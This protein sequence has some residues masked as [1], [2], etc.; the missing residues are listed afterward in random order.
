[1]RSQTA[2]PRSTLSLVAL[3]AISTACANSTQMVANWRDPAATA[4]PLGRTLAVFMSSD[5]GMRRM[6]EDKLAASLPGG[7]ASYHLI[8]DDQVSNVES[9]RN[10]LAQ[11]GYDGIVVMRLLGVSSEVNAID[12]N[13][14]IYGYWRYW[15]Y[16]NEP[17]SYRTDY[18]YS[19]ESSLYS[20]RD[21]RMKWMARSQTLNPKNANKLADYTVN[22]AVKNLRRAGYVR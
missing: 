11:G 4:A 1:M 10:G 15:G 20:A 16:A 12:G 18:L 6:V 21:G 5:P 14:D 17:I 9:L 13:S 8:P 22:F 7:T 3:L 2:V 19:V